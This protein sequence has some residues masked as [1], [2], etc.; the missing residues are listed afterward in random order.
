MKKIKIGI[1]L[2]LKGAI[3]FDCVGGVGGHSDP[4]HP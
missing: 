2:L 3:E 1:V 4:L